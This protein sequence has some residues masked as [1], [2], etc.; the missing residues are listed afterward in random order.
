VS[1]RKVLRYA[2]AAAVILAACIAVALSTGHG[3]SSAHHP[4]P[5]G[6]AAARPAVTQHGPAASG[7]PDVRFTAATAPRQVAIAFLHG[8]LGCE[9][10]T[11]A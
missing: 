2:L 3:R 9:Y 10:H 5:A 8:W 11:S 6:P 7:P 1:T 4:P